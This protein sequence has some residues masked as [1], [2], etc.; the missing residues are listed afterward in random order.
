MRTLLLFSACCWTVS[1]AAAGADSP[2]ISLREDGTL[3]IQGSAEVPRYG[4]AG[5]WMEMTGKTSAR[6]VSAFCLHSVKGQV[7][8]SSQVTYLAARRAGP[9]GLPPDTPRLAAG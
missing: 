7:V 3:A 4:A 1:L 8:D 5:Q 6:F 9:R 2:A